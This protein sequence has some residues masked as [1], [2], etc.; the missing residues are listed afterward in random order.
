MLQVCECEELNGA[1]THTDLKK[2]YK[3]FEEILMNKSNLIF[4]L[5]PVQFLNLLFLGKSSY[6][7][8]FLNFEEMIQNFNKLSPDNL[9]NLKENFTYGMNK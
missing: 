9:L 5:E 4:G 7:S 3:K 6:E 2:L 8:L 1:I